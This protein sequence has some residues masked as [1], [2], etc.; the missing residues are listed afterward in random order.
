MPLVQLRSVSLSHGGPLLLDRADLVIEP[1]DRLGL[2]GRNGA[3][4][5]TLMRLIAGQLDA[6]DGEVQR[7]RGLRC[8]LLP[9]DVPGQLPGLVGDRLDAALTRIGALGQREAM[10]RREALMEQLDLDAGVA[11]ETLSAGKKRRLLLAEA[12]VVDPDLLLLDEPTNHLDLE[13]IDRLE[14]LLGRQ[15]AALLFVTH[16]RAFLRRTAT[17]ILDL[18]RGKLRIWDCPYEVFLER[19]EADLEAEA[20]RNL[21]FDKKL[22]KEEAWLRRGMKARR[23]RNMGRVTELVRM[24]DERRARREEIG[25]AR[26]QL[27]E[28]RKSGR[29]VIDVEGLEF[30]HGSQPIVRGLDLRILRGDRLGIVGPNGCGKTTLIGLLLGGLEPDAGQVLRGTQLEVARFDQLHAS[31]DLSKTPFENIGQGSDRV[32]IGGQSQHVIGYLQNFLFSPEQIMAP[33]SKLSGGE[34]NRLQLARILARPANLLVLDEP[35]NDLDLETLELLEELLADYSGT[36]VVVSHDRDFLDNTV[37]STLV[38]EGDGRWK[39]YDGGYSDWQRQR[40]LE[41]VVEPETTG[42][43]KA[44]RPRAERR[45]KLSFKEKR[46]LEALPERIEALETERDAIF[47]LMAS[48]DFYRSEGGEVAA[49]Q[50]RLAA[51]EGEL[52]AAYAR[53]EELEALAES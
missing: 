27:Q 5:S 11:A 53:W 46:E 32:S 16:D 19:K 4:K 8:A 21:Q 20:E 10:I 39:E 34:R 44:E 30:S 6:D 14:D 35:T 42:E 37:S 48:P 7:S 31:L 28:A 15:R 33:A 25:R 13:A 41:Q 3:G 45:R 23:R 50:A 36:L 18:D 47:A 29:I 22:A 43:R 40:K 17:R 52:G 9:Q 38:H 51:V 24:R 1:G 26:G 2:V 49:R 12:L